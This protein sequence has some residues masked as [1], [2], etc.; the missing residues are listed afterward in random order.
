MKR[1]IC[2]TT[3]L[4][5]ALWF[6]GCGGTDSTPT[7]TSTSTIV[8]VAPTCNPATLQLP[9]SGSIPTSQ[10]G[11]PVQGIGHFSNGVMWSAS[12]GTISATGTFT[13]PTVTA[14]TN[15]TITATSMQDNTKKG[16]TTITVNP[17]QRSNNPS[18]STISPVA[19]PGLGQKM[20]SL[21]LSVY[22]TGGVAPFAYSL[23]GQTNSGVLNCSVSGTMLACDYTYAA[24]TNTV[25]V[26]VTDANNA[27][28]QTTI[29]ITVSVPTVAYKVIWDFGP[30]ENGQDPNQGFVVGD[31]QLIQRIGAIAPYATTLRV[32]GSTNGLQDI[33]MIARRFNLKVYIGVWLSADLNANETELAN[34][35]AIAQ[36]GLADAAIVG[37]EVLLRGDLT[38]NQLVT[39]MSRFRAGAPGIPVATADT[40]NT[41]LNNPT[42][43]NASDFVF[44]NY[45]GYWEGTDISI[46][47]ATLNGEDI[48][49]QKTF[50]GKE[51]DVSETGWPSCGNQVG[52]AIPSVENGAFYF[53]NISSWAQAN[54]R[55]VFYFESFDEAY[56]AAYEGPQGA[57]WGVFDQYGTMKTGMI[58]VFNG[59]TISDNWTCNAPPGADGTPSLTFTTVPP[60]GS[61]NP[62]LEQEWHALPS[63]YYI[64]IYIH[65]PGS[66]WWIKPYA[67]QPETMINCDGTASTNIT[68]GGN[69]S[70]ADEITGFLLPNSY[71]PPIVEG[72]PSLPTDLSA[73]AAATADVHR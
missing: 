35:I 2:Q 7:T 67:N 73:N 44:A 47:V 28:A 25:T 34:G 11:A 36:Q 31:D 37:S 14:Q 21:D 30:S 65:V 3:V 71:S 39:Y 5:S 43:V 52:N 45:F 13:P 72:A 23:V 16:S 4:L 60:I 33:A 53:L 61:T 18:F 17:A 22:E 63:G 15:V 68:T 19:I 10:C 8:S 46:A 24:G 62:L 12:V 38:A 56:K 58:D 27:S 70:Q 49:M 29:A 6:V 41:L 9:A 26:Q 57:C 69:D 20:T 55:K 59:T 40:W 54:N 51:I 1:H 32:Y 64:A 42:V 48:E 66:G 50:P